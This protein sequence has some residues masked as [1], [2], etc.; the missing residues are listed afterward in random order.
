MTL[1]QSFRSRMTAIPVNLL[2]ARP[3]GIYRDWVLQTAR[4]WGAAL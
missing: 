3:Y 2:T 1:G 4:Q